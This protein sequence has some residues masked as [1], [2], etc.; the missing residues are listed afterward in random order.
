MDSTDYLIIGGGLAGGY[1]AEV[2]R[3]RD[4]SGRILVVCDEKHRPYDRVPLSKTYLSGRLKKDRLYL[5]KEEYYVSERIEL[6]LGRRVDRIDMSRHVVALDDSTET[7]FRKL[8]IASGGRV[9]RLSVEGGDLQ[10]I[11]YLRT[12]EDSEAIQSSLQGS[13]KAV[14]VGG[15][16]IGCELASAFASKGLETTIVEVEANLLGRALDGETASWITG[17][18]KQHSV[19]VLTGRKVTRFIGKNGR[20]VGVE[21]DEGNMVEADLVAVGV[22]ISPNT[23]LAVQA[24]LKVDNGIV[25]DEY[26]RA[27]HPDIYAA[28]D[29]ANFYSPVFSRQLRVEHYDVAVKHGEIAGAN[30]AGGNAVFNEVPYFFSHMFDM[31]IRLEVYGYLEEYDS[32]ETRGAPDASGKGFAKFYLRQGILNA[33]LLIN[34]VEDVGSIKRLIAS[35][36]RL[37][38]TSVLSKEE[39]KLSEHLR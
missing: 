8:L 10:C 36:R 3:G 37:E 5:E 29:V 11:Y 13:R 30:M 14:A 23:D 9:R 31:K 32:T 33:V 4:S 27:S 7:G 25:V 38:D 34:R 26:L 18:F 17:Y 15:G 19:A 1:A 28:G 6:L 22:G 35:R 16:F 21:T 39:V 20:V 2:I 24:G 12:I